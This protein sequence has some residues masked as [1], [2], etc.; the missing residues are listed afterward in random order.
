M[1]IGWM[2]FGGGLAGRA[3]HWLMRPAQH[4]RAHPV[5]FVAM[6]LA[7]AMG[8]AMFVYGLRSRHAA[9]REDRAHRLTER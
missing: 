7:A 5:D 2:G 4:P 3:L 1:A 6:S 9:D 8:I